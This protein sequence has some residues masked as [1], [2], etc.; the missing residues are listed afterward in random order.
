V[1]LVEKIG[2][3]KFTHVYSCRVRDDTSGE[4][5]WA[6]IKRLYMDNEAARLAL[7]AEAECAS[8]LSHPN[9]NALWGQCEDLSIVS[10]LAVNGDLRTYC[11]KEREEGLG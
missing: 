11:L 9:M 7:I 5:R 10:E 8:R 4:Q 2:E 1:Q 6:A 3:G